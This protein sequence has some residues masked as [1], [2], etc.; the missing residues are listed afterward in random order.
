MKNLNYVVAMVQLDLQDYTT[1]NQSRILQ[2]AIHCY[3]NALMYK[4]NK[5]IKVAYLTPNAV[6]NA[7]YPKDYEYYTKVAINIGSQLVTLTRNNDIPY[8]RKYDCGVA[9][10]E[11]AVDLEA[12]LD[13]F[14]YSFGYYYAP[15]YRNGQY[16][17]E[18]YSMGGGFN[19]AG[20]FRED[21]EMRQFQFYNVP[22]SQIILEYVA[23]VNADGSLLI[24]NMDVEPIRSYIHWQLIEHDRKVPQYDKERKLGLHHNAMANRIAQEFTPVISDYLDNSYSS[25]KSGPK[26]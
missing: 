13:P 19:E 24:T 3:K 16:V 25:S 6:L 4:T 7:P 22:R 18:M 17:G 9:Q 11:Q 10:K 26:R 5:A 21:D 23:D 1:H 20:Y 12:E 15:H 2:Y 14:V 8:S